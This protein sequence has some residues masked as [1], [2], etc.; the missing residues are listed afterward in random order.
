[1]QSLLIKLSILKASIVSN[2]SES[3]MGSGRGLLLS[4]ASQGHQAKEKIAVCS[5]I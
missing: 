3:A 1:M 5:I 2:C 4:F